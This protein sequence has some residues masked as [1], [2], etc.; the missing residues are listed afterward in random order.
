[1]VSRLANPAPSW[2]TMKRARG[3]SV[4]FSLAWNAVRVFSSWAT[5]ADIPISPIHIGFEPTNRCNLRCR[6][7]PHRSQNRP[8]GYLDLDLFRRV[9]DES[10]STT[11]EYHLDM[12]GEP[13]LHDKIIEMVI[14]AG[15]R[16]AAVVLFTNLAAKDDALIRA[17]ARSPL[18]RIIVNLS[19]TDRSEYHETYGRDLLGQ[20]LHNLALLRQARAQPGRPRVIVKWLRD[21][22][23]TGTK[24]PLRSLPPSDLP[25]DEV[26][27]T[28]TH[29]WL[30]TPG[31]ESG[32]PPRPWSPS[33]CTR[34]WASATI[35]WDGRVVACCYDHGGRR[36]L[37]DLREATLHE[38]WNSEV[39]R[40]FRRRHRLLQPCRDCVD[41]DPQV[42]L[43]N[44]R[45]IVRDLVARGVRL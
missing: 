23:P 19:T 16:G 33:P 29:D 40:D 32:V 1:M 31:V 42:S 13:L 26:S 7:C 39:V 22:I 36:I 24:Y 35:L 18:D 25:A 34:L 30:G 12:M 5:R 20:V 38:V 17:L 10:A 14:H 8:P 15:A 45:A 28:Y 37:G 27:I 11:L 2:L 9:V 21:R 43:H 44:V 3:F 6:F 41:P 4:T